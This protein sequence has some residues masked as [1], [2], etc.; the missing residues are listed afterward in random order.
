VSRVALGR[1][2]GGDFAV[3]LH[4]G[5]AP[6]PQAE[7]LADMLKR[8]FSDHATVGQAVVGA[9][10][11]ARGAMPSQVLAAADIALAR[12]ESRGQFAAVMSDAP[13]S[14][15]PVVGEDEWRR[16]LGFSLQQGRLRL[17]Q[18]PVVNALGALIH[19]ECPMRLQW[20]D[21]GDFES[22]AQWLHMAM[23]CGFLPK[24][25]E[26]A[27]RLALKAIERDGVPRG[28]NVSVASLQDP[29]FAHRLGEILLNHVDE[30]KKLWLEVSE[31]AALAQ[32][33]SVQALCQQCRPMGVK[34]GLEHAGEHLARIEALFESGLDYV[35]LDGTM[36]QGLAAD[37]ARKAFVAASVRMLHNLG[38]QV[39]AEGV[40]SEE[41]LAAL[42]QCGADGATGPAIRLPLS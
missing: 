11:W 37:S 7:D 18:F 23:R 39:F 41:D 38:L 34:V 14:H 28:V 19:Q 30:A 20:D 16:R 32:F 36:V 35:K 4:D 27:V 15:G 33:E 22:A 31:D 21:E 17:V 42:W 9:T 12:A 40:N 5:G 29:G 3:C 26:Q 1:L 24:I 10:R 25:D 6:P 8:L 13:A 2:N